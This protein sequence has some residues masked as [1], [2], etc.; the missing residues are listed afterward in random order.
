MSDSIRPSVVS[1]V[2]GKNVCVQEKKVVEGLT[3]HAVKVVTLLHSLPDKLL[4]RVGDS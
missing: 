3:L 4:F 2:G 1:L